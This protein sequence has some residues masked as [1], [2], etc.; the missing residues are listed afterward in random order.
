[1]DG[2]LGVAIIKESDRFT[3]DGIHRHK[4][5]DVGMVHAWLHGAGAVGAAQNS[6]DGAA[7]RAS[8]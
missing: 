6:L 8:S 5:H 1:M 7:A 3:V 2:C 4:N